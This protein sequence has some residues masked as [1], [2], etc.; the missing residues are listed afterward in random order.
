MFT[1]I[2]AP[3]TGTTSASSPI[4]IVILCISHFCSIRLYIISHL[5]TIK[6]GKCCYMFVHFQDQRLVI[7]PLCIPCNPPL[8]WR[9]Q[10]TETPRLGII[11]K[12]S[13]IVWKSKRENF[14]RK[15]CFKHGELS[16]SNN[17]WIVFV[18]F[19]TPEL[20]PCGVRNNSPCIKWV[21]INVCLLRAC[22]FS[23][24]T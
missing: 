20:C 1:K 17:L 23:F 4:S 8:I 6:V 13:L 16:L 11:A 3:S 14:W 2:Y 19:Y 21:L 5:C 12:L 9:F 7:L 22:Y 18:F 10:G 24:I 15:V